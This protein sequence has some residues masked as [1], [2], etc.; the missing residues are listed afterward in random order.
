MHIFPFHVH[1]HSSKLANT[2]YAYEQIKSH[3]PIVLL[4]QM[5]IS[6]A[7]ILSQYPIMLPL[8]FEIR[9]MVN[10]AL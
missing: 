8:P 5:M 7:F 1:M 9:S 4:S 3:R 2:Y 6:V 10:D